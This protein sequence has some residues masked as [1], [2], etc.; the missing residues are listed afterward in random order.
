MDILI[1]ACVRASCIYLLIFNILHNNDNNALGRGLCDAMLNISYMRVCRRSAGR[2][3]AAL[4]ALN[5]NAH[6]G[7]SRNYSMVQR[8]NCV[9]VLLSSVA[10]TVEVWQWQL[11]EGGIRW[12]DFCWSDAFIFIFP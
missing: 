4:R 8:R 12:S 3:G 11:I 10:H 9:Y 6:G 5:E 7:R 1:C 2:V